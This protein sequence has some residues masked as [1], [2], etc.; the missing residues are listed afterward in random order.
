MNEKCVVS[1]KCIVNVLKMI[2]VSPNKVQ[3]HIHLADEINGLLRFGRFVRIN[4]TQMRL[5]TKKRVL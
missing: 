2:N 5:V 1:S 4:R 3:R